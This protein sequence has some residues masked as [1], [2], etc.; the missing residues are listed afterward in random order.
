MV[1]L[2]ARGHSAKLV[3]A[4]FDKVTSIPR[5]ESREITEK[6]FEN[7]VIFISSFNP[8]DPNVFQIINLNLYLMKNSPFLYNIF[9]DGSVLTANKPCSKTY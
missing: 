2:I 5:H 3:K 7:K 9:T 1:S 4:E 6:S 8:R